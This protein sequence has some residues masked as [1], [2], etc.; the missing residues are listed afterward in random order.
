MTD[1]KQHRSKT[2][3]LSAALAFTIP[4]FGIA[5]TELPVTDSLL[6]TALC[7]AVLGMAYLTARLGK[8]V[9]EVLLP[10]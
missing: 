1:E 3:Y 4:V 5:H 7:A 6:L 2:A 9:S 8:R 10:K